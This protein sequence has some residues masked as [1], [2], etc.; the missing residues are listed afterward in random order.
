M[1]VFAPAFALYAA[2]QLLVMA[3]LVNDPV[4]LVPVAQILRIV[5]PAQLLALTGKIDIS[6]P[7]ES[8]ANSFVS[9]FVI[10]VYSTVFSSASYGY[11]FI[12]HSTI[13][14]AH[15]M[16]MFVVHHVSLHVTQSQSSDHLMIHLIDF[17]AHLCRC[18]Q[19]YGDT[20]HRIHG[21]DLLL[22]SG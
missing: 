8:N 6:I 22:R 3:T 19:G 16:S 1:V 18:D 7:T 5:A 2:L 14:L 9:L 12:G 4:I 20:G 15:A 17:L 11:G 13:G 10:W 21:Q